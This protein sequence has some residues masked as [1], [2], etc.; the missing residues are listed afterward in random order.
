MGV[1]VEGVGRLSGM[2]AT[3]LNAE[4]RRVAASSM[5]EQEGV[6]PSNDASFTDA[7]TKEVYE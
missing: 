6:W 2:G 4:P 7:E 5:G 1:G 3:I